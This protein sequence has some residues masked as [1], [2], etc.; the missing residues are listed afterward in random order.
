MNEMFYFSVSEFGRKT[1]I[2]K[3]LFK[4]NRFSWHKIFHNSSLERRNHF[5]VANYCNCQGGGGNW[6]CSIHGWSNKACEEFGFYFVRVVS[7]VLA[8]GTS[9]SCTDFGSLDICRAQRQADNVD[10]CQGTSANLFQRV[11]VAIQ[12]CSSKMIGVDVW[13]RIFSR[14]WHLHSI[15]L[16]FQSTWAWLSNHVHSLQN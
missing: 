10:Q 13:T 8:F 7:F 16:C 3:F 5:P 9:S 15:A 1:A 4:K 2:F 14:Q 11:S 6:L 12:R